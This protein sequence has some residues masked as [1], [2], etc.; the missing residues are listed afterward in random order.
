MDNSFDSLGLNRFGGG[1]RSWRIHWYP[2]PLFG[3][4]WFSIM[5]G[6]DFFEMRI[7]GFGLALMRFELVASFAPRC[8]LSK[9]FLVLLKPCLKAS[10]THPDTRLVNFVIHFSIQD[11]EVWFQRFEMLDVSDSKLWWFLVQIRIGQPCRSHKRA[12]IKWLLFRLTRFAG[13]S[14]ADGIWN[15]SRVAIDWFSKYQLPGFHNGFQFTCHLGLR[16]AFGLDTFYYLSQQ[17]PRFWLSFFMRF[18]VRLESA[19]VPATLVASRTFKLFVWHLCSQ[20]RK[21]NNILKET[22]KQGI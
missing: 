14:R 16:L 1:W 17:G 5:G 20:K 4:C 15:N 3:A 9:I 13:R 12:G 18:H 22:F 10:E 8:L 21:A 19:C 7:L 6:S 2:T 11:R